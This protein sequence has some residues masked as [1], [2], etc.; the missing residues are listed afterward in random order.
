MFRIQ[1]PSQHSFTPDH[2]KSLWWGRLDDF[3]D[4][5]LLRDQIIHIRSGF[6]ELQLI[7]SLSSEPMRESISPEHSGELLGDPLEQLLDGC[8]VANEGGGHLQPP[9]RNVANSSLDIVRNPF[10]K[11]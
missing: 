11:V 1:F 9:W 5:V 6:S 8:G 10:N 2:A 7:H 3:S 4:I